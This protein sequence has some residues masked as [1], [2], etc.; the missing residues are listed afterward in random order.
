MND[1]GI[2]IK[3]QDQRYGEL[4][5]FSASNEVYQCELETEIFPADF[6]RIGKVLSTF[7]NKIPKESSFSIGF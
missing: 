2:A 3:R 6:E 7:P 4:V 1:F 5:L